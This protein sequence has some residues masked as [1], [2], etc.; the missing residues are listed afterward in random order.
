VTA[1]GAEALVRV[2]RG[3]PTAAELA[4]LLVALAARATAAPPAVPARAGGWGAPGASLRG[5]LRP[6]PGAWAAAARLPARL[7]QPPVPRGP[8]APRSG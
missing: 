5:P 4:A 8:A 1:P 6:G 2:V 7:G 3:D